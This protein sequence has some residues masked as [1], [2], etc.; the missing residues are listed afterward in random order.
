M[1]NGPPGSFCTGENGP[2]ATFAIFVTFR[3]GERWGGAV[4]GGEV[5]LH[6]ENGLG[7]TFAKFVSFRGGPFT[8]AKS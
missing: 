3:G 7:V 5:I 6:S 4:G 2:G 8:N 1:V